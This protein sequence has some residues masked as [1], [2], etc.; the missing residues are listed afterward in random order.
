[1]ENCVIE[2]KNEYQQSLRNLEHISNEIHDQRKQGKLRK[3]LGERTS[4]VGEEQKTY[5]E[6]VHILHIL[7]SISFF[8]SLRNHQVLNQAIIKMIFFVHVYFVPNHY[9]LE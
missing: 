9:Q 5:I 6:I 3:E 2:A 8:S 4:C 1:L 7:Y